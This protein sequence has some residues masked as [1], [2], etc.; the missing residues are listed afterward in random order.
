MALYFTYFSLGIHLPGQAAQD[1]AVQLAAIATEHRFREKVPKDFP[2]SLAAVIED[3]AFETEA[4]HPAGGYGLW[5]YSNAGG[6]EAVSAF[7]QHLLEKFDPTGRITFEWSNTCSKARL[8]AYGG[9]AAMITTKKIKTFTT[10][11]W[12]RRQCQKKEGPPRAP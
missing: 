9:G 6:I 4:G 11:G 2:P 12:L 1:Y 3:W 7:I 10:G 8:D 5:L